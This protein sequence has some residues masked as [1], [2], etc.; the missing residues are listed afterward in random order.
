L[1]DPDGLS[2]TVRGLYRDIGQSIDPE[3]G[4]TVVG[5]TASVVVSRA[6]LAAVGLDVPA[7][8]PQRDRKPWLA[9][10]TS[11]SGDVLV[12]KVAN[13]MPDELGTVVL[14]LEVYE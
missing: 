7:G 5:R 2:A 11:R 12:F 13:R 6:A 8:V 9:E 14:Q 1:T 10:V 3:T 4:I